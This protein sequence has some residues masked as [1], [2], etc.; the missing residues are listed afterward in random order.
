MSLKDELKGTIPEKELEQLA[1]RFDIIGDIAIISVPESMEKYN[2]VVAQAIMGRMQNIKTVL[3]KVSKLEGNRRIAD[4][5][6]I[7]GHST[8]TIHKE[9]GFTYR[10]DLKKSFFNGRLSFERKRVALMVKPGE[11]ILV[12]FCGVGPFAIPAASAGAKVVAVEMNGDACKSFV[13]N[14][15]LNKVEE[16]I[17]TI[18]A[19]AKHIPNMIKKQFDRVI[20]P[21]PYG[22]D[23]FLESIS[24]FVKAGGHVHFYTFKPKEQIP[25]LIEKYE[26]LGFEVEFHRRCGNVA[27]GISRWAFDLKK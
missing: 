6:I 19:D 25:E 8:E 20:I 13:R 9:F 27:P 22:M 15:K 23:H 18:N 24:L 10:I 17:Q 5:K 4:F 21:T 12:P 14:C 16:N 1:N 2:N 11:D 7:A 26:K 3:N